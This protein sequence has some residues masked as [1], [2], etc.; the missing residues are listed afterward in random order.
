[1]NIENVHIRMRTA[2]VPTSVDTTD[3]T[4]FAR[5]QQLIS[6]RLSLPSLIFA[7]GISGLEQPLREAHKA[8]IPIIAVVDSDSNPKVQNQ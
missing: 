5:T 7:I 3:D 4:S 1:M 2:D 6:T 8:G